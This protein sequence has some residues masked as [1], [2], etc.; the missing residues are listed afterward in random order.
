LILEVKSFF[1]K[2]IIFRKYLHSIY[3]VFS[4]SSLWILNSNIS[5]R[6][7]KSR[8]NLA[9]MYFEQST[10]EYILRKPA[11]F[12]FMSYLETRDGNAIYRSAM[13]AFRSPCGWKTTRVTFT[14]E[15]RGR[16]AHV[17]LPVD[18]Y[19]CRIGRNIKRAL[20][21]LRAAN[22]GKLMSRRCLVRE[23]SFRLIW[24]IHICS[25]PCERTFS[26]PLTLGWDKPTIIF[27]ASAW[28]AL[29][30]GE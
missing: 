17:T 13:R 12:K 5:S 23:M 14:V 1:S 25:A 9:G 30:E 4:M 11:R 7:C 29:G 27:K 18:Y 15:K 24:V 26:V 21:A 16:D 19:S 20:R 2:E 10:S 28:Y 3:L 6:V 22:V 8:L